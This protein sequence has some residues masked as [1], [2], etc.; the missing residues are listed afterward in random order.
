VTQTA[1]AQN[2]ARRGRRVHDWGEIRHA[3]WLE[4]FFDLVFVVAVSRLG[5]LLHDDHSLAGVLTAAGL[6][7][8]VWWTWISFSYYADLFD[9]DGPA[10]RLAQLAAMLGAGVVAVTLTDGVAA[11]GELFA[12]TFAVLF[13]L[14]GA[15]YWQAGRA[16]L[17]ARALC[18]WY[19]AGSLSGAALWAL[20][21]AVPAPGRYA[22]WG[23]AVVV[24]ALVSG[25]LAYARVREV[26]QQVS[27]M[28]ERFGLFVIV[29][30][31]ETVL[32]LVDGVAATSWNPAS[33]A[34]VVA[35]FVIAA[36][37]WWVYFDQF[38]EAAIDRALLGGRGAQVRSFAY[39]YGHLLVYAAIVAFGV[40]V[41]LSAEAAAE[42]GPAVPLLGAALAALVAGFLVISN[43][44]G[45]HGAP[46]VLSAK[47][48]LVVVGLAATLSGLP[49]VA[50]TLLIAAGWAALVVLE[51]RLGRAAVAS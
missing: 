33:V 3:T 14:L 10:D 22:L 12:G 11:D 36:S 38:D 29:V 41:E 40:A 16:E 8:P 34:T 7:V 19:V 28:P 37:I 20:S 27:H 4:L 31:G 32:A 39:G 44:I 35:G 49:A 18:R 1:P 51:A 45:R 9:D 26:P 42:S 2:G 24:N 30:L 23:A 50:A 21:I 17:R 15:M 43:G 48:G 25:P 47:A 5:V 6:L 46:A 13:T